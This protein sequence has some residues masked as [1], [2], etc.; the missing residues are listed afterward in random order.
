MPGDRPPAAGPVLEGLKDFQRATVEHAFRRLFLDEDSTDRF[1]V[2][3]EVGLGKT[4]VA[5]G[6][7]AKAVERLWNEVDRIDVLY[8][9]SNLDI[10]RQNID[11]LRLP[12]RVDI[13]L[14][15]RLTL[16]P[17]ILKDLRHQHL[18]LISFTP[19]TSLN[20]RSQ[21]GTVEERALLYV[22]LD[23][24]GW[25][26]RAVPALN[27]LQGTVKHR[28]TFEGWVEWTESERE[29]DA[30]LAQAFA[31]ALDVH[32]RAA[33]GERHLRDRFDDLC[34][35]FARTRKRL[36]PDDGRDRS[37][38][39]G[40]LRAVLATTCATSLE[41]DL[42]ILDEF[43]RFRS[44]LHNADDDLAAKLAR[45]L[46]TWQCDRTDARARLLLLS[47]TPYKP[48]TTADD[49]SDD[50]YRD[51]IATLQFLFNNEQRAAEVE[52]RLAGYKQALL[53]AGPGDH[54]DLRQHAQALEQMLLKVMCRT[55]RLGSSPDRN[56]MLTTVEDAVSL[57]PADVRQYARLQQVGDELACP[58]V[59]EYWKSS[60]YALNFM[61]GYKLKREL[62]KALSLDTPT[63]ELVRTLS[64][65]EGLL[66]PW[67]KLE[68]F[69]AVPPANPRLTALFD[70]T[71]EQD[72]WK[73]VWV[74]PSL[75][76]YTPAGAYGDE[77]LQRFTK[78][79]VFS[80][81]HV[82]PR[83][84]SMLLSYEAERRMARALDPKARNTQQAREN[85]GGLLT[86]TR[87]EGR[88]TGMPVLGML[89]P[90]TALA[91]ACDPL[92]LVREVRGSGATPS[93]AEIVGRAEQRVR[94]LLDDLPDDLV[95]PEH[96]GE[97]ID[98]SAYPFTW[99]G[100]EP[101][102]MTVDW[103][104]HLASQN[105]FRRLKALAPKDYQSLGF[106]RA[107]LGT[108]VQLALASDKGS[109]AKVADR[110]TAALDL[111][112]ARRAERTDIADEAWYWAT[113]ILLDLA[114]EPDA[115]RRWW[116]TA[117][118]EAAWR[119]A[120]STDSS[121]WADHVRQAQALLRGAVAL[122]RQPE[123]LAHVLALSGVGGPGVTALRAL[124][125]ATGEQAPGALRTPAAQVAWSLR[126]RF[127]LPEVTSLVRSEDPSVRYWELVLRHSVDGCLQA[128]LDEYA[129]VL[130][131]ALGVADEP[132][133]T[134]ADKLADEIAQALTLR[135]ATLG[136]DEIEASRSGA[137]LTPRTMRTRFAAQF[138]DARAA[139]DG[140][141][142]RPGQ[143]RRAF[144]SP[145]WPFVLVTTSVGQE[146]LDFHQYCHAVVHWN[147]PSNPV[148]LE[149]REGRV[150]RY[151][152]HAV[153]RNL[154]AAHGLGAL[155][156][157]NG[158]P[159]SALFTTGA[160]QRGDGDSE[161]VPF[162]LY[163]GPA[164]IERHLPSL[165]LSR[166][167]GRFAELQRSLAV[168]RMAFGQSRQ[169]D[170]IAFLL[171]HHRREDIEVLLEEAQLDLAP[172]AARP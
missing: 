168:Y 40:D 8:I 14:A 37:E 155:A 34:S 148:D 29:I 133:A 65:D 101:D 83:A 87:T 59:L 151:K 20:P 61:E 45:D 164:Q 103:A 123:D 48:F 159:W 31:T 125:R 78:R 70:S 150:H 120:D 39:I 81:W 6:I 132:T 63:P 68:R 80:S 105:R 98:P 69:G 4:L 162:W 88:L 136:V 23:R 12:G 30:T 64:D 92:E 16:L 114:A 167:I 171:Q 128:V 42:I 82:V 113:P 3:D 15:S 54:A 110:A 84:V 91:R 46:F 130:V 137:T 135:T 163:E 104:L 18:N 160:E 109:A 73:L 116:N 145:F 7:V 108:I 53:T 58:G 115:T 27:L 121:G 100:D 141:S 36:P 77:R 43:Q 140:G 49:G 119:G 144:N 28:E 60:P 10:A 85:R 74:P 33:L 75:P 153:R 139:E 89:Y 169:D 122:G 44:L 161:L 21:M 165:P 67:P 50:H 41:P 17:T 11:R 56:G 172:P 170:L 134:A 93:A 79:L 24:A 152:S 117:D 57:T 118:L 5:K 2:A 149:Q 143:V 25:I 96:P 158:D 32:D 127:N 86:F 129:H 51:F 166:E 71:V 90:S 1:L 131:E 38:L 97:D 13:P 102:E 66:L 62:T 124:R 94:A 106:T 138:A 76:Y 146:G 95:T 47:A 55:E 142:L 107:Q 72:A 126:A 35:R 99:Q 19:G 111:V 156:D 26:S 52:S 157:G 154:A 9:C 112:S 147:L 22:L